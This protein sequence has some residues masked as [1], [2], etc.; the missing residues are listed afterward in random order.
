[1]RDQAAALRNLIHRQVVTKATTSAASKPPARVI[2]LIGGKGGVGTSNLAI[3]M[4]IALSQQNSRVCVWEA[5]SGRGQL[6]L[7]CGLNGYWNFSH[8]LTGAKSL[9]EVIQKGP[10]GVNL[11]SNAGG[12]SELVATDDRRLRDLTSAMEMIDDAYDVLIFDLGA[13]S[14]RAG[15]TLA[16]IADELLL[17][18]T[19]EPTAITEAYAWLKSFPKSESKERQPHL[20]L[21][22]NRTASSKQ[23]Q[24]I[25]GRFGQTCEMFLHR[26]PLAGVCVT[27]DTVV[28]AAV[29]QRQPFVLA[30]PE[31]AASRDVRQIA[32]RMLA[33]AA[34][35]QRP[36]FLERVVRH[37]S[38]DA[39]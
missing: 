21:I 9:G 34:T 1:M 5:N 20:E 26:E 19:P 4:G 30:C 22:I 13:G 15:S 3:N 6:E 29:I 32:K 23:A 18:C 24:E 39:D 31:S 38:P 35:T 11:I 25:A 36:S 2:G 27:E 17:V 12:L 37:F 16:Q 8:V 33:G 10:G 28:S 14:N 7:L